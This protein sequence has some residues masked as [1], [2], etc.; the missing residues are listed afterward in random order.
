MTSLPSLSLNARADKRL[1]A[2]HQWIFSNEVDTTKTPLKN[3]AAGDQVVVTSAEGRALGVA[4]VNPNTLL[5]ARMI[6]RDA[7]QGLDRALLVQRIGDALRLRERFFDAPFYRLVYGDSDFLSGLVIDRFDDVLVV[8]IGAA[9]MEQVKPLIVE[10][11]VQCLAP[12]VIVFKNDGGM[13]ELESL[14][15]YVEA[16]VG[17]LPATVRVRENGCEFE[18]PLADGQKTGW[19][20]DHRDS[21]KLLLPWVKGARVLDVF[22]YVGGW[23]V[24]AAVAGAASVTCVDTSA[25][26]LA[27]VDSNAARNGVGEKVDTLK[28]SAFDVLAALADEGCK[29]DVVILDPPAF[30]KK[31]KDAGPGLKA[32]HKL[33]D[34]GMRLVERDGLLVSAS[35]SMHLARADLIDAVRAAGRHVDR[36]VQIIAQGHQGMDHPIHP[37]IPETEYLKTLVSR[38]YR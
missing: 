32:Y 24:Q 38:V 34:L 37:A 10:A 11:L 20:Y 2:G 22:S 5:C 36:Q 35:C 29:Y 1:R 4:I 7:R 12:R 30:I 18:A 16:A 3:V 15:Q 14:P 9:G 17:E 26:A 28:G 6:S 23:G 21:R 13:R 8:Q 33:N 31:R 27:A 19:F 25:A